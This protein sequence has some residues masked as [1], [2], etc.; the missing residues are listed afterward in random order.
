[1]REM[2]ELETQLHSWAPRRPSAELSRRLFGQRSESPESHK[3]T[4]PWR[5]WLDSAC[6]HRRL[7]VHPERPRL[8]LAW[9]APCAAVAVLVCA[10]SIQSHE[11]VGPR[12]RTAAP[13]RAMILSNESAAAGLTGSFQSHRNL[14]PTPI[15]QWTNARPVSSSVSPLLRPANR[16]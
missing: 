1:M 9:Y 12:E 5:R 14:V 4:R 8:S 16:N 11:A 3:R 7:P 13:V 15:F 10:L 2:T 6:A